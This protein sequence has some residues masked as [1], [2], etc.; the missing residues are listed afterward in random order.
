MGLVWIAQTVLVVFVD[1]Q[2]IID[3][4]NTFIA[5]QG[6]IIFILLVPLN[7]QVGGFVHVPLKL[8]IHHSECSLNVCM[9]R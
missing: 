7:K 1:N 4:L 6:T 2:V 3:I 9:Y 5:C 8:I